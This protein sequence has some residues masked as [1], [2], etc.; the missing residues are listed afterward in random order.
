MGR[1]VINI[2]TNDLSAL[3]WDK[4]LSIQDIANI[5]GV[6]YSVVWNTMKRNNIPTRTAKESLQL[7]NKLKPNIKYD[8]WEDLVDLYVNQKLSV[9]TIARQK[10]TSVSPI[11][12]QLEKAGIKLRERWE[13]N[14]LS[15]DEGFQTGRYTGRRIDNQ[16]YVRIYDRKT[17]KVIMEH[18]LVWEQVHNKQLPKGWEVHHLNG[19]PSDNRPE[20]LVALSS[21]KHKMILAEKAQRIRELEVKVKLLE[22]AL[23]SQQIIWWGDN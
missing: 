21:Q 3:Y 17:K 6:S 19:I 18:I 23:D 13:A 22:K 4:S 15:A 12:K 20:N 11:I 5:K 8:I 1:R 2:D 14:Q 10:G 16:G 9:S 7:K